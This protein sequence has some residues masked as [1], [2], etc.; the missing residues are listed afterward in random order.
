MSNRVEE[1]ILLI[2]ST[3]EVIL[4]ITSTEEGKISSFVDVSS[5]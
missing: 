5:I 1:V 2:T 4:F 3:E